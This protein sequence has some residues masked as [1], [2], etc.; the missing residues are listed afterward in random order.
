MKFVR[1]LKFLLPCFALTFMAIAI[2][3]YPERYISRCFEGFCIWA[4]CVL[5]SLFPFMTICLIFIKSGAANKAA[6]P[7]KRV[8]GFLNLPPV[9]PLCFIMS[10]CSG[11]P[12]GSRAVAEFYQNGCI[13]ESDGFK[14]AALCSTSGPLFIVGTV[15]FKMF[16]DKLAGVKLLIA[17]LVAVIFVAIACSLFSKRRKDLPVKCAPADENVIYNAFFGAVTACAAAAAFI[18][19]FFVASAVAED[20]ALFAPAEKL[21][22]PIL[23]KECASALF[24]GFFEATAGCRAVAAC[25]GKF[26]LPIAGFLITFGGISILL[27]Q[28]SYLVKAKVNSFAFIGV[29]FVQALLCFFILLIF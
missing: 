5:P 22:A 27:Q 3:I 26:A 12:A 13:A 24:T 7:L 18:A 28:T 10:A 25:G 9:A 1:I 15:G 8:S 2:I 23:G 4:E 16:G 20:F 6:L 14:L 11:Y 17:H 19:F 21:F 29:K